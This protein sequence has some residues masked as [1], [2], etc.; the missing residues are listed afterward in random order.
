MA[1]HTTCVWNFLIQGTLSTLN[2]LSD[3]IVL[4]TQL[5]VLAG[6]I[7]KGV[8]SNAKMVRGFWS[9]ICIGKSSTVITPWTSFVSCTIASN[10]LFSFSS[11]MVT[12]GG[13]FWLLF[14]NGGRWTLRW[15]STSCSTFAI[16]AKYWDKPN[17]M[18]QTTYKKFYKIYYYIQNAS[19]M[20]ERKLIIKEEQRDNTCYTIW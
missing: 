11:S 19:K 9:I 16:S 20:N 7:R 5:S 10:V 12:L 18:L 17:K 13:G 8:S 3:F 6:G 4:W 14:F 15:S 1:I 2:L